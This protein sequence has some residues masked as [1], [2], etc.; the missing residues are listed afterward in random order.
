MV[1]FK[2]FFF[3][4]FRGNISSEKGEK[5]PILVS[6]PTLLRLGEPESPKLPVFAS[7]RRRQLHLGELAVM[8]LFL[9]FVSGPLFANV[10]KNNITISVIHIIVC[11][12]K[13]E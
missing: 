11:L 5:C 8:F 7:S 2:F 6:S 12:P 1:G 9:S 3:F 10:I 4:C 13:T